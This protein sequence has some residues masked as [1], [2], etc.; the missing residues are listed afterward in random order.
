MKRVYL[1]AGLAV[2]LLTASAHAQTE[3]DQYRST[4]TPAIEGPKTAKVG[5]AVK[6]QAANIPPD[7]T[8]KWRVIG[9]DGTDR[10]VERLGQPGP[11]CEWRGGEGEYRLEMLIELY[12]GGQL[13]R[14]IISR[15]VIVGGRRDDRPDYGRPPPYPWDDRGGYYPPPRPYPEPY[16]YPQPRPY[17]QPYPEQRPYPDRP[18]YAQP[19]P[20]PGCPDCPSCPPRG[21]GEYPTPYD[22]GPEFRRQRPTVDPREATG[23][24]RSGQGGCSA[25]VIG[26]R[27]RDGRWDVLS[28]TH[29]VGP[30]GSRATFTIN[31]RGYPLIVS[32]IDRQADIAWMVTEANN[33]DYMPAARLSIQTPPPGTVIQHAGL[34]LDRPG[35]VETGKVAG[36]PGRD[37]IL[38]MNLSVSS[39]DSGAPIWDANTKEVIAVVSATASMAHYGSVVGG[40]CTR[41][42]QDRPMGLAIDED[43]KEP[44][45]D[46][47]P[48]L[49]E[50]YIPS[51]AS[52]GG[53]W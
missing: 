36:R 21:G 22:Q 46:G 24:L 17:P 6:F 31:G 43:D 26:P 50:E 12:R 39:G 35:N 5:E 20:A 23:R 53:A 16:P 2:I 29:C 9:K 10:G 11:V 37:G 47:R 48:Y 18:P 28:A 45:Y 32:R 4:F 42:W 27:R 38:P 34:G 14:R 33:I 30:V 13:I 19:Y 49:T 15:D 40:V 7:A 3:G 44:G 1:L 52:R 8:V 51:G 41:A 25:T